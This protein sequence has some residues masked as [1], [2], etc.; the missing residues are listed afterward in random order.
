MWEWLTNAVQ[1]VGA[2][3]E[4]TEEIRIQKRMLVAVTGLVMVFAVVWGAL[5][6]VLGEPLA[7]AIPLGYSVLT[8]V[9]L[10]L[11]SRTRKYQLFR[12]TQLL[13]LLFLLFTG[14]LAMKGVPVPGA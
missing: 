6:W 10:F 12:T 3:P 13:L 11:F 4:D 1:G 14:A 9:N 7:G 2:N 8:A 5:F